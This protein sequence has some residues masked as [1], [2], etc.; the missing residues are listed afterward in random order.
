MKTEKKYIGIDIPTLVAISLVAWILVIALYRTVEYIGAA[1][2]IDTPFQAVSITVVTL[3]WDIISS[4]VVPRFVSAGGLWANL[5]TGFLALFLLL[6]PKVTSKTLR[7]FLWLFSTFSLILSANLFPA[8]FLGVGDWSEFTSNLEPATIRKLISLGVGVLL[9][10]FGY[11]LPLRIWMPRLKGNFSAR[12]KITVIPV[13]TLMVVQTLV[14]LATPLFKLPLSSNPLVAAVSGFPFFIL[15]MTLVNLIP[16]PRSR[17]PAESIQ[18]QCS[19][20][21]WMTGAFA[22]IAALAM[23]AFCGAQH[24][25]KQLYQTPPVTSDGWSTASLSDAGMDAA[26][27][28]ELLGRLDREDGHNIQSLIVAKDGKLVLETYY[29][30]VDMT[31][32]DNLI[33]V[34][35]DVNRDTLHCLASASKSVTSILFGIA[36]DQGYVTDLDEKMFANF[37]DYAELSDADKDEITFRQMLTMTTGLAWDE[38]S[39]SFNDRR[40][41][42]NVMFFNPDPVKFMLEKPLVARPG[43]AFIYNSGV[44][45]L[46]G[47]ILNRKTGKPLVEFAREN[48]F[49]PLGI[50]SF[51]W[52]TFTNA[53]QMALTSSALY[54]KPRDIAK[55]GQLY[56][57]EGVWDGKQIISA[58]WVQV[59]TA[60]SVVEP[61]NYSP[62]FQNTGYGYQWWR[63]TFANGQTETIYAAGYGGQYIFIMPEIDTVIVL[64]G[65]YFFEGYSYILDVINTYI[66]GSVYGN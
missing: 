53:P 6:L 34:R 38:T 16:V 40:N 20:A 42:L 62:A 23:F 9:L 52:L 45:N 60:E 1:V 48:L 17:K 56:L 37:P 26:P 4:S 12:I 2:L 49:T 3:D 55:I 65:S 28:N 8:A 51:R 50:T 61:I 63:G 32:T 29:P 14:V 46:M 57:Q 18:F 41:D 22:L 31:V 25:V 43:E 39:Y 66:L 5:I 10:V 13:A 35:K 27:I 24:K 64:T 19:P 44:T 21:W 15:W 36:M 59:S 30:G 7:C 11:I 47:E 54:L 33:F 58:Q